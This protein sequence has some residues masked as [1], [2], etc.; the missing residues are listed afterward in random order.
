MTRII[1]GAAGSLTLDVPSR[2]TRPTS[3][4]VRES[5][6]A[7]LHA[8]D[9]IRGAR[10]LDLFAGSGA[11]GLEALSRGATRVDLVEKEP[12]AAAIARSNSERVTRA[13]AGQ[14]VAPRNG[15]TGTAAPEDGVEH[16]VEV[17]RIAAD[18]FLS[19]LV[20]S[21]TSATP[22]RTAGEP[23]PERYQLV[24]VD[25]PYDFTESALSRT[26]ELL[27][28]ALADGARVIVERSTRSPQ[29]QTSNALR[30]TRSQRYGDTTLWWFSTG[31]HHI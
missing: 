24:F 3:D 5:L 8:A 27:L 25:P 29:P 17:H 23:D 6:F 11:L 9:A 12:R 30:L 4:R 15:A 2:G 10:V 16:W 14:S 13:V 26:L 19:K 28:P 18:T 1:A 22:R 31:D 21:I 7:A 20:A